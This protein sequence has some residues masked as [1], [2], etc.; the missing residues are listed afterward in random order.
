MGTYSDS[1]DEMVSVDQAITD[2][3]L[4]QTDTKI[5]N[6]MEITKRFAFGKGIDIF[7]STEGMKRNPLGIRWEVES[8]LFSF[9]R[10]VP[11]FCAP[12]R[13]QSRRAKMPR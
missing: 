12:L 4:S 1:N 3:R 2:M 8:P 11:F 13:D 6:I 7:Y 10:I 9:P 5:T